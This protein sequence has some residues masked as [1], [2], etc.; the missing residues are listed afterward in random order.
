MLN[1][2]PW[3]MK[4]KLALG[5][6]LILVIQIISFLPVQYGIELSEDNNEVSFTSTI[7]QNSFYVGQSEIALVDSSHIVIW[8]MIT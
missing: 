6:V 3:F 2:Q 5:M 8:R 7:S 4:N 1:Q